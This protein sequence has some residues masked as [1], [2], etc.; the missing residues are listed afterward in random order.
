L[1]SDEFYNT[2]WEWDE[3]PKS[4]AAEKEA[5]KLEREHKKVLQVCWSRSVSTNKI[6][7]SLCNSH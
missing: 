1:S 3:G 4:K 6:H 2:V 5:K 7:M